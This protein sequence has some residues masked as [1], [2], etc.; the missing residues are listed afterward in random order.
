MEISINLVALFDR[1]VARS[2]S[3]VVH[4]DHQAAAL[5]ASLPSQQG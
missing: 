2:L 4:D 3:L 1:Q 5:M